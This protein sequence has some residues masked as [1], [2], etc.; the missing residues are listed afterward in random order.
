MPDDV[1][2]RPEQRWAIDRR[3]FLL[4]GVGGAATLAL[5]ACGDD[6]GTSSATTPGAGTPGTE[7]SG[8]ETDN[9]P[10]EV[11][12]LPRPTVRLPFGA[13]GFPSPFSSNGPPG[14]VQMSLLYDTLLWKDSTGELLPWLA[15]SVERSPDNLTYTFQLRDGA[16]WSDG[17]PLTADD[18]VF[19]FDYY[20]GLDGLPPPVISQAPQGIASVETT[21]PGIVAITLGSPDITFSEQVAGT[22]PIL[23]RH[24][25]EGIADP[26]AAQDVAMLVGSGPY[27]LESGFEGDGGPLLYVAND[28]Y[29]LGA[30]FVER[31]E[32]AE[33]GD[34]FAALLAGTA[35]SGTGQGLRDDI[36]APFEGDEAYGVLTAKGG[37]TTGLYFNIGAGGAL[38]DAQFRQACA[39]AIDRQDLV[40]RL[41][42]GNG[43]AGNPG[44]LGSEN[45]F[46]VDV[47]QYDLDVEGANALLDGAGYPRSDGGPRQGARLRAAGE[48]RPGVPG[49]GRVRRAG[50]ARRRHHD[51][52]RR[53]RP[54]AVRGQVL[55]PVPVGPPGVPRPQRRQPQRRP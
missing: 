6:G 32:F 19:T 27:R 26:A 40:E 21:G 53:A 25:W 1:H 37:S 9:T 2:E 31:I 33:V 44:F 54:P 5:G 38:A 50:R 42:A 11:V 36:V 18:V 4:L 8:T 46:R 17:Q 55:R 34:Q 28:D 15:E 13:F 20:A 10:V 52:A 49:R 41:A 45:P 51:R 16:M 3:R 39:M 29:F 14:Y 47:E 12:A 22:I 23:P 24:I 48:H 43:E 7:T 30:P 35:D